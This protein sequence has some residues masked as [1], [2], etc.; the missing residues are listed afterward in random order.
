MSEPVLTSAQAAEPPAPLRTQPTP[1][2]GQ[3]V[4]VSHPHHHQPIGT[5]PAIQSLLYVLIVALFLMTF[6]VQPI[7][8]PSASMEPTL[9]VGDFLLLDRQST[10]RGEEPL[11]PPSGV[12]RGDIIVFHDPVGDPAVH[13]VKRVIGLPGDRIHLR[14]GR[15]YVNDQPLQELYTRYT[16]S[17]PDSFRDDFPTLEAMDLRV[18]PQWWIRLRALLQDAGTAGEITVPPGNYFVLGDNRNDSEDSR[19][20]GFVPRRDIVGKPLLV[21][22][23]WREPGS[24]PE[25]A[26]PESS[27]IR[28][29]AAQPTRN[30]ARWSRTFHVVH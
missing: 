17:P 14:H 3:P 15:V 21:Y 29:D 23:S 2:H 6:T 22:F 1:L 13:L 16:P 25:S 19:Y 24:E 27:E 30:F 4:P 10:V 8:I 12:Q 28:P 20:W 18:D 11:L 9:L 5:L 26:G 7:R